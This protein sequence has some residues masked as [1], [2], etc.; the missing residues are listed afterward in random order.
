MVFPR[1]LFSCFK[2][3]MPLSFLPSLGKSDPLVL[4]I[5]RNYGGT[6]SILWKIIQC[7]FI[8]CHWVHCKHNWSHRKAS[9]FARKKWLKGINGSSLRIFDDKFIG[10]CE[11]GN[12]YHFCFYKPLPRKGWKTLLCPEELCFTPKT[13]NGIKRQ[14][15]VNITCSRWILPHGRRKSE[16]EEIPTANV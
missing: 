13:E 6:S 11:W 2:Q 10:K 15:N 7:Y 3:E 5:P 8:F 1:L 12:C 4:A 16:I 14:V 9:S